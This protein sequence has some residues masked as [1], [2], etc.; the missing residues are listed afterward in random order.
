VEVP[1]LVVDAFTDKPFSGNQAGVCLLKEGL[2]PSS[3]WMQ[4]VAAEM[5][6]AET[7]FVQPHGDV[8]TLRWFTPTK[9]VPLC[10]HATLASA[11]ALWERG[12]LAPGAPA[13]FDT[14]SGRLVCTSG[15]GGITMDF[16]T[17]APVERQPP[18]GLFA[19]LGCKESPVF[20]GKALSNLMVVLADEE[21]VAALRPDMPALR[22]L[23]STWAYIVT[24]AAKDG[25]GYV[26]RYFAPAWGIDEDPATGSIACTLGPYWA[27]QLGRPVVEA[28]QLSRRGA[29]MLVEPK[30]SRTSI[31]GTAVTVLSG[32]LAVPPARA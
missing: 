4:D 13:L 5:N 20:E 9:E 31:T 26:V 22:A 17:D 2:Q 15:P 27:G 18:A 32:V 8:F 10:G 19:A 21:A 7:A 11:H 6:H 16:P 24:A 14:R 25:R 30:G 29:R 3:R 28:R 1:I 12:I 23:S